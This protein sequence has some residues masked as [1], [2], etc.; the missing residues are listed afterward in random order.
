MLSALGGLA[1]FLMG[2]ERI[3]SALRALG[4][5][6]M[7]RAMASATSSAWRSLA[8]G[9]V[10][11]AATQSGTATAITALGL[12]AGAL[13]SVQGGLAMSFGAQIGATI[14]IQLAAFRLSEYALPMVAVGFLLMRWKRAEDVGRLILGA[15]LLFLGLGLTVDGVAGLQASPTFA[16]IMEQAETRPIGVA[17]VGFALGTVLTSTNAVAALGLGLYASGALGLSA[18]LALVVGGNAGGTMLAIL[19]ARALGTEALRVAV[20]HTGVKLVAA[21]AVAAVAAPAAAAVALLGGDGARQVANAHTLFNVVVALP[22]TLGVGLLARLG[23]ALMPTRSESRGPRFLR[24]EAL[25]RPELALALAQRETIAMSDLV[26]EMT[27]LAA[28]NLRTGQWDQEAVDVREVKVDTLTK[29]VIQYLADLRSRFGE[30][31][32]SE[33]LLLTVSELEHVGDQV[34]RLQRRE[35][36]LSAD[37]VEYSRSGRAELAKTAERALER[38]RAAFT[39]LATGDARLAKRVVDERSGFEELITDMRLAHLD[40]LEGRSQAARASGQHHLEVLTLL[41]QVDASSS[42]VAEWALQAARH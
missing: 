22:A 25:E 14:A 27:E 38:Q 35:S 20:V 11:S 4:G 31:P 15:G 19:A 13:V 33:R 28:R 7:R 30:D 26:A 34:R 42:R 39:A 2:M 9:T 8:T 40:R 6:S 17:F 24:S 36:K 1:L 12:V 21:L 16:A 23:A 10:V 3:A 18:T 37:G 32:V 29:E 41:R 5:G